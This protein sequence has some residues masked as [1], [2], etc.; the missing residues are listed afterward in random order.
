MLI[1]DPGYFNFQAMLRAQR[2][3]VVGVPAT[4]VGPDLAAFAALA[5]EHRPKLYL[6]T[7]TLHNPTGATLSNATAHRLLKLAEAYDL[8][9]VE[10]DIFADFDAAPSPRLAA[11]DGFERVIHLGSFSKTLSA[12][13]RCGYIVA[14][15]DWIEGLTDLKLATS[16]GHHDLSAQ[17]VGRILAD[18]GYRR[19]VEVLRTRLARA[20]DKV[21]GQLRA[22]GLVPWL[23]PQAGMFVWV[24][25]P[26]G[27][28]SAVLAL[29]ALAR[30]IVLAPGNVF[31][32]TQS[33]GRFLRF[34]VAQC[35]DPALFT[36]LA[37]VMAGKDMRPAMV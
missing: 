34:N 5:G 4:P 19:H 33:A 1:D 22:L 31:S 21:V 28:D 26:E 24:E 9:V 25:L 35:E 36:V 2:I 12:A 18:G 17:L 23:V 15:R 37:E 11:M 14:K 7:S 30:N 13:T 32:V 6:T 3:T 27:A 29:K 16:F 10:D 20:R 8:I